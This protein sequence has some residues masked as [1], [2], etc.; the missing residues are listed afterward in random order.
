[1][2]YILSKTESPVS[3]SPFVSA[4][5]PRSTAL[6]CGGE[7]TLLYKEVELSLLTPSLGNFAFLKITGVGGLE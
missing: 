5:D 6:Q 2:R 4:A 3:G 1:M 7:R